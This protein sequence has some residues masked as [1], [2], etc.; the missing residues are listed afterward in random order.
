[1]LHIV[2][3]DL[4]MGMVSV[5]ALCGVIGIV[6]VDTMIGFFF[7]VEVWNIAGGCSST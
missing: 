3:I 4:V 1:M 5:D 7:G 6:P 2:P